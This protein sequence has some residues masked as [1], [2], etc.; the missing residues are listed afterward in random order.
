MYRVLLA[1]DE[2]IMLESLKTII[3][4]NFSDCMIETAK[5]GRAAIEQAEYFHPDIIFM[6]IQMP[7]IDGIQALKEIRSFNKTALFYIISAY[8]KFDYAK[9]AIDQGVVRYLMKPISKKTVLEIM[10]EAI[11][12][13][14]EMRRRHSDQL[15]VQEKLE[16]IIPVVENG[17]ITNRLISGD[18][19]DAQYYRQLLD[20]S[21]E[22]GYIML[23]QFGTTVRDGSYLSPVGVSVQAQTFYGEFRAVLKSFC[24]C[25]IGSIMSNRIAVAVPRM[26]EKVSY[27]HRIEIIELTR[28]IASR[29]EERLEIDFRVGIGRNQ[30]L[31]ELRTSYQEADMALR[32]SSSRV[33]H[34]NDVIIRGE[35]EG[36]FPGELE[37]A[38]FQELSQGNL[39][40]MRVTANRFFDWMT[41]K[42]PSSENNIRLKVLEYV[43]SAEKSAFHEGAVN[44][45]FESRE[46]YLTEVMR[47]ENYEMLRE[48]F[49]TKMSDACRSIHDR[50]QEQ[51]ETVVSK[52]KNYILDNY[53]KD[54]SLD[55]VSREV[56]VSPY[57]FSK[58]FKEEAKE[59]FIEYLTRIRIDRAKEL[60]K[61][62]SRTVKEIS[63]M[64]GYADPNYFSRIFKKHTGMT[65]RE[66]REASASQ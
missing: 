25:M 6:D 55:D 50:R 45:G 42:Y 4:K 15:R 29:L 52:A 48:W 5:T 64:T 19:E 17:F 62:Q 49:L 40:G 57:Y 32:E 28:R 39:E 22:Y 63:S 34:I 53:D 31:R 16:T 14:D 27:E 9:E 20:I 13:V 36:D 41:Q 51:S 12:R 56:N 43:L 44:Y 58:L 47:T 18:W 65:P 24:H 11:V 8:D 1:D 61:G 30:K 35:Y 2:G 23:F 66:F 60:L 33:A 46:N 3:G 21:E 38:I 59:N 10:N 26:E 37:Q 54:I 7:G